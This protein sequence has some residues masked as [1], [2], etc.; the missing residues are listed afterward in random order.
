MWLCQ[1]LWSI[2]SSGLEVDHD[3]FLEIL[4]F[5]VL[6]LNDR[7]IQLVFLHGCDIGVA[8]NTYVGQVLYRINL[9]S[10]IIVVLIGYLGLGP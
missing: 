1:K 4:H 6:L 5:R 2:H 3:V 10:E 7:L 9:D 8:W